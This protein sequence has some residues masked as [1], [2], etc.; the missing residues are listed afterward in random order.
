M[1]IEKAKELINLAIGRIGDDKYRTELLERALAALEKPESQSDKLAKY[2]MANI[3]GEPS[4]NEGAGDTA[5]RVMKQQFDRIK[6]LE[7]CFGMSNPLT[8]IACF[9]Q[10]VLAATHLL[11]DHNCDMHGYEGIEIAK[12]QA[13]EYVKIIEQTLKKE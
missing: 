8:L 12:N 9:K 11:D 3:K 1:S 2:I 5:I 6:E 10:L 4:Q 7:D 13:M